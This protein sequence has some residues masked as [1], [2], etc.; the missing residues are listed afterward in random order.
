MTERVLSLDISSK[1]GFSVFHSYDKE[2]T[3][4]DYGQIP[5]TSQPAEP[6]PGSY[7]TWAYQIFSKIVELI[8]K[9]EPDVLV[10][11]ETAGGSK[12]AYSQKIL[13]YVHF[14]VA[15]F[16]RETGIKSV[17]YQTETWRRIVG[18]LMTKEEKDQNK[19]IK[20][21]RKADPDIRVVKDS[22]GKRIGKVTRKHV[23][24]RRA[25]ELLGEFLKE[26]LILA[27]EDQADALLLGLSYH[28]KKVSNE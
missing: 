8:E 9:F 19:K 28:I 2:F 12:S 23:N 3:L 6:Y 18:C 26:P 22:K 25:N 14:L 4:V 16:I 1:T 13:E 15:R 17:Y 10:I 5:K 21:V 7:V 20:D 27:M 11:E 24:V